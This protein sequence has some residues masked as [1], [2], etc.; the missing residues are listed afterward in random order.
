MFDENDDPDVSAF[1]VGYANELQQKRHQQIQAQARAQE[2]ARR[3]TRVSGNDP[4]TV[5]M[6]VRDLLDAMS[7]SNSQAPVSIGSMLPKPSDVPW[8]WIA[9]LGVGVGLALGI[10]ISSMSTKRR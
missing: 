7:R 5:T 8:G 10:A 9:A 6:N 3:P 1:V 4:S 2:Q